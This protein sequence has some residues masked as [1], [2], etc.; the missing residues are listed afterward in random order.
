MWDL[1]SE[2]HFDGSSVPVKVWVGCSMGHSFVKYV[3]IVNKDV[4]VVAGRR[5]GVVVGGDDCGWLCVL[6]S[7]MGAWYGLWWVWLERCRI[8]A[9]Q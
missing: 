6:K 9:M 1:W 2:V 8:V 7:S 5:R 3:M 4:R